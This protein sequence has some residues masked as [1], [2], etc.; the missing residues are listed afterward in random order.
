M[1]LVCANGPVLFLR[2]FFNFCGEIVWKKKKKSRMQ[3]ISLQQIQD[4]HDLFSN[5]FEWLGLLIS[6]FISQAETN[7]D[8]ALTSRGPCYC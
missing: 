8:G 7:S 2:T 5:H 4:F 3:K 1:S 6:L